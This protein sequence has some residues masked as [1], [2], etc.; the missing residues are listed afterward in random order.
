LRKLQRLKLSSRINLQKLYDHIPESVRE[1]DYE[2]EK[3]RIQRLTAAQE[4][5]QREKERKEAEEK[6]RAEKERAAAKP[7]HGILWLSY[8]VYSSC[9]SEDELVL[10]SHRAGCCMHCYYW[11]SHLL[12]ARFRHPAQ[13]QSNLL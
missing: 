12:Q 13:N 11:N 8:Q 3:E 1:K 9:S 4:D 7:L 6:K 10:L 5:I 2:Q